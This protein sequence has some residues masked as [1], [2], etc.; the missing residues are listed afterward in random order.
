[1]GKIINFNDW[2][3]KNSIIKNYTFP[4]FDLEERIDNMKE[5]CEHLDQLIKDLKEGKIQTQEVKK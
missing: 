3:R 5:S 2:K 4:V 1:M